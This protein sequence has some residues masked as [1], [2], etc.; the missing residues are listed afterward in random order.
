MSSNKFKWWNRVCST[1]LASGLAVF[2]FPVFFYWMKQV[3]ISFSVC[4]SMPQC[5]IN[6]S[7]NILVSI[8]NGINILYYRI[9]IS[10][11]SEPVGIKCLLFTGFCSCLSQIVLFWSLVPSQFPPYVIGLPVIMFPTCVS[12]AAPTSGI[13]LFLSFLCQIILSLIF[14]VPEFLSL[15]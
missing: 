7:K 10:R 3:N 5:Y 11:L 1:A 4:L 6:S 12:L 2:C 8:C 13:K 15:L 9:F 14:R